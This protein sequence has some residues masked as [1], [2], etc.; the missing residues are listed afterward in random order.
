MN[1]T[2][3]HKILIGFAF[4]P[5]LK[6]NVFEAIRLADFLGSHLYFIH[7]GSKSS[8]KEKTFTDILEESP[9]QPKKLTV[10]WEEGKPVETIQK[11]CDEKNID[12][13]LLGAM[14]RENMLK[15]YMGS[16][17]R[18]LTRNAP[19]S[20]LLLIKPSVIRKPSKHVIVNA[21]ESSQTETTIKSGLYFSQALSASKLTLV[22]EVN[23]S[24]V[25]V[26]AVDDRSLR[27]VTLRKEKLKRRELSR[28]KEILSNIPK[29]LKEGINIQS[30]NIFGTRGYSI[31]HYAKVVRADLLVMNAAE[32]RKGFFDR[33]F[34]KDLEHILSELPTD[35]LIIK[36]KE[37]G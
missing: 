1:G 4:S 6:A 29:K 11:Q 24:E 3:F 33:F 37:N 22:E 13:L 30:Q 7:V 12:L 8:A 17:A 32:T 26:E 14:Q 19:C 27:K 21:F 35:V 20:V 28:V 9:V 2:L 31:G 18:K 23:R 25:A 5:N 16:I 36:S 34:P 15:F 10:L